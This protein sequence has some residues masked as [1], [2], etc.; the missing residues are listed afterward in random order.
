MFAP[1]DMDVCI[2]SSGL[3]DEKLS[4]YAKNNNWS[5][6]SVKRNCVSLAQNIAINIHHNAEYIYK[7]D[8][9][10]FLTKGCFKTLL[11]TYNQAEKDGVY[12]VGFVAPLIPIN[13]YGNA[14]ILNKL[15]LV[16]TYEKKFEK[17][18]I[19]AGPDKMV[20]NN[21]DVAKFF[22]G[23]GNIVPSIDEM[24]KIFQL[25]PLAYKVCPIRFSIGFILFSRKC[26]N[27]MGMWRVPFFGTAMGQDEVQ[28]CS[29]AMTDSRAIIVSENTV[30]GHLSFGKQNEPMKKY[31][32][33]HKDVFAIKQINE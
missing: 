12:K 19:A 6:L 23:E 20:E 13:G 9:D 18:M 7:M 26:W 15:N 10:I 27:D 16:K 21:P 3:Y 28:I 29:C 30:V 24:N 1:E 4:E 2:V 33:E 8:E 31:F 32:L 5:Y 25:E 17:V 11:Q 22:W 14:R